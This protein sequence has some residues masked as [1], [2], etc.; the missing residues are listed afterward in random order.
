MDYEPV[1]PVI[2]ILSPNPDQL[3]KP[4]K[5]LRK[6]WP[7]LRMTAPPYP[8]VETDYYV[9]EFGPRLYRWWG[10]R[11][12]LADPSKLVDW[13]LFSSAV[14]EESLDDAGN[15]AINIDPG[16]LNFSLLVLASF[17]HNRQ[18]IYLGK[19]VYA[20]PVLRYFRGGFQPFDWT[21][22]DFRKDKYYR[23][24]QHF[25]EIYRKMRKN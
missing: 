1:L 11:H 13:K 20:D 7:D 15:R 3:G 6:K 17:K 25:R 16:Y 8:F 19:R 23:R 22:P 12:I 9:D 18:K 10:Y 4:L 21:F 24:L 5:K 2:S 14:E